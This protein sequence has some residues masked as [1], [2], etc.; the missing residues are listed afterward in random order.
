MLLDLRL[1]LLFHS[2]LIEVN[3]VH[4]RRKLFDELVLVDPSAFAVL[5]VEATA[6]VIDVS[7]SR[8]I[9]LL[10]ELLIRRYS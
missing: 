1:Y 7:V 5:V 8:A 6:S 3:L 4:E 10:L 9:L 2:D